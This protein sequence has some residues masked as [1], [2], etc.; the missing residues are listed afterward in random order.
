MKAILGASGLTGYDA[1]AKAAGF[2]YPGLLGLDRDVAGA[3]AAGFD[4]LGASRNS[5][6]FDAIMVPPRR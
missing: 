3:R 5:G 2:D 6:A 4:A 1:A